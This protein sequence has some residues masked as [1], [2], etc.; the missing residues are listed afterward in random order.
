MDVAQGKQT[1]CCTE[2]A[3]SSAS[4]NAMDAR[5]DCQPVH[6]CEVSSPSDLPAALFDD[7]EVLR[8]GWMQCWER[9][10]Q[11]DYQLKAMEEQV[12]ELRVLK[13]ARSTPFVLTL[14][15]LKRS[16]M[17][18]DGVLAKAIGVFRQ[19]LHWAEHAVACSCR[20]AAQSVGLV[21][22]ESRQAAKG[23]DY[24]FSDRLREYAPA[25]SA[26][27]TSSPGMS[28]VRIDVHAGHAAAASLADKMGAVR[29][30]SDVQAVPYAPRNWN[31]ED[32][33]RSSNS[34]HLSDDHFLKLLV[35]ASKPR[36]GSTLLQRICNAKKGTLIW[37]E[38][39]NA[40]FHFKLMYKNTAYYSIQREG[41]RQMFFDNQEN[42]NIWTANMC[43][44]PQYLQ[45]AIVKST[46]TFLNAF[47]GQFRES[48]DTIG[49]KEVN[50]G[51]AEIDLLLRCYPDIR[52]FLLVRHPDKV[53]NSTPRHW[54]K[55][56]FDAW[57]D[58]WAAKSREFL[59]AARTHENCHL[60]RYE[61]LVARDARTLENIAD[62]AQLTPSQI[63]DVLSVKLGHSDPQGVSDEERAI[64][65]E[66]CGDVMQL[67]DYR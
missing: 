9:S 55:I 19:G 31:L 47:Y 67:F 7:V 36:S 65:R 27:T 12:A 32:T 49:F 33:E 21:C 3:A 56:A 4:P 62:V 25:P 2:D 30:D 64:I 23:E 8:A 63:M 61:D 17:P 50:Y 46:R 48:H 44:E 39:R 60:I 11:L 57:A 13:M 28:S 6:S 26:E 35:L 20:S 40:L 59:L 41:Q 37:G 45:Q 18:S 51:A 22:R 53:W 42:P 58:D 15:A 29:T 66:R 38:H 16:L 1:A 10:Q 52:I 24:V 43:P 54:V 5:A 14:F 34:V